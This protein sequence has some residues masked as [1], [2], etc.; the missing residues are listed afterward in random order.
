MKQCRAAEPPSPGFQPRE[1]RLPQ[2][3]SGA[4]HYDFV[5]QRSLGDTLA[6]GVGLL[7][8]LVSIPVTLISTAGLAWEYVRWVEEWV[9]WL[10]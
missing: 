5:T 6:F 3:H 1:C 10:S 7:V 9:R 4:H 8:G 2:G